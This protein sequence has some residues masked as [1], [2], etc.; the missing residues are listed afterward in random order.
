MKTDGDDEATEFTRLK[1]ALADEL[2]SLPD[3]E[4]GEEA[5]AE[6]L[7]PEAAKQTVLASLRRAQYEAARRRAETA[8]TGG[9]SESPRDHRVESLDPARARAILRKTVEKSQTADSR[10]LMAA[11][12]EQEV[13]DDEIRDML[14]NLLDLGLL[15]DDDFV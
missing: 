6:G 10:F 8:R 13:P 15:S 4:I 12:N 3:K 9:R 5:T 2:M 14:L 7:T 11:R 1:L